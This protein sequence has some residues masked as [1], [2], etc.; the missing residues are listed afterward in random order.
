MPRGARGGLWCSMGREGDLSGLAPRT[1]PCAASS[2][3]SFSSFSPSAFAAKGSA[4]SL[5]VFTSASVAVIFSPASWMSAVFFLSSVS[6]LKC[7]SLDVS[8]AAAL[9]FGVQVVFAVLALIFVFSLLR[10]LRLVVLGVF[11]FFG[12]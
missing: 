8:W 7:A 3:C 5:S 4:T 10:S 6:L 2:D 12:L 11:V 1:Y 9:S